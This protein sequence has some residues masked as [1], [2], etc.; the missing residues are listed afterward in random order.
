[1]RWRRRKTVAAYS[2]V[3]LTVDDGSTF[4]PAM[5]LH[6]DVRALLAGEDYP[7]PGSVLYVITDAPT[8]DAATEQALVHFEREA[9][10]AGGFWER[11][12][13]FFI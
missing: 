5:V 4:L 6:G 12:E 1:M 7:F 3:G 13:V 2:V 8:P 10:A 11:G 9:V